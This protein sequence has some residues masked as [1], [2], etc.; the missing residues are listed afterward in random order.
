[1]K[2]SEADM[3]N[4]VICNVLV[5]CRAPEVKVIWKFY[6]HPAGEIRNALFW[7]AD[8]YG[9][10]AELGSAIPGGCEWKISRH[11]VC[12]PGAFSQMPVVCFLRKQVRLQQDGAL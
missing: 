2:C 4:I 11:S 9:T 12:L 1:M 6:L 5:I 10:V 3:A 7:Q 8:R